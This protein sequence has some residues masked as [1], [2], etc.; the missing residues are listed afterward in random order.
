MTDKTLINFNERLVALE[1]VV[2]G[3][4][5]G[6]LKKAGT[7]QKKYKSQVALREG[8]VERTIERWVEDGDYPPPDDIVNGRPIWWL[9]TLQAHDR[10][11]MRMKRKMTSLPQTWPKGTSGRSTKID[12]DPKQKRARPP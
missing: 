1:Q 7:D 8:V 2:F 6:D 3:G 12:P 10:R 11:R 9:S 5:K 4:R